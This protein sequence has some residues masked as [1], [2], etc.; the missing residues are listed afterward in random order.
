MR[1]LNLGCGKDIKK[2]TSRKRFINL[3]VALLKGVDVVADLRGG[4]PFDEGTFDKVIAHHVLE[5]FFPDD[6]INL[7][8]EIHRVLKDGGVIDIEVPHYKS[9]GA[10]KDPTHKSFFTEETFEYFT[11]EHNLGYYT[12]FSFEIVKLELKWEPWRIWKWI[13]SYTIEDYLG[14]NSHKLSGTPRVIKCQMKA[15]KRTD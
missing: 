6:L 1:V 10:F 11:T 9:K 14:I 13:N 8:N 15:V 12:D 2:S 5:H 3:D 4:I 7:M